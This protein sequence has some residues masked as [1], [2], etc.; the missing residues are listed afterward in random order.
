MIVLVTGG[1]DYDDLEAVFDAIAMLHS[2]NEIEILVHGDAR[3]ADSLADKVAD[4][5]GIQRVK[6][7]ANWTKLK[8]GAGPIRNKLMLDLFE[9]DV[10][11]AFPGDVGTANMKKQARDRDIDVIEALDLIRPDLTF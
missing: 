10:V 2:V 9:I 8:R 1:R 3:G 5:L 6:V 4:K 11:L 7:P